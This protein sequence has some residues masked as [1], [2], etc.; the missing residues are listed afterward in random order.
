MSFFSRLVFETIVCATCQIGNDEGA[1]VQGS[2]G[3]CGVWV[4]NKLQI[5]AI[6]RFF[7]ALS[8]SFGRP[9]LCV[10]VFVVIVQNKPDVFP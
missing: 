9:I 2:N 4:D 6:S 1:I 5:N 7:I 8:F 3:A 10:V